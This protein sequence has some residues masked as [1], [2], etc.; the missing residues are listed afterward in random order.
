M[1]RIEPS[2]AVP[3]LLLHSC[4]GPCSSYV[5]EYLTRYFDITVDYYNPNLYPAEEFDL[6]FREQQRLLAEMPLARPVELRR[7]EYEPSV[8][9]RAVTGME[10]EPEGGARCDICYRLRLAHAAKIAQ[11]EGFDYFTT[12]LSVSPYKHADRLNAIGLELAE[13]YG[14]A[15]LCS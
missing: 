3:R 10:D 8:F 11:A 6:R 4:C 7:G 5:L 12:T 14:V 9:E 1:E 13:E 2:G 15:Y